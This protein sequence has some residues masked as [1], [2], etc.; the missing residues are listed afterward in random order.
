MSSV[1]STLMVGFA[2][3]VFAWLGI[4]LVAA[5]VYGVLKRLV[6]MAVFFGIAAVVAWVVFFTG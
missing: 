1:H 2:H 5:L 6:K 3:P 4:F